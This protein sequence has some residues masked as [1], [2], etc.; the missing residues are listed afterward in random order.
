MFVEPLNGRQT[1]TQTFIAIRGERLFDVRPW[2][3]LSALK[4]L[5]GN[6]FKSFQIQVFH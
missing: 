1:R 4:G 2:I 5:C 3:R 6:L